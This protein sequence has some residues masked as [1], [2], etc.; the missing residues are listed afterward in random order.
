MLTLTNNTLTEASSFNNWRLVQRIVST[1]MVAPCTSLPLIL[2]VPFPS[3]F[4][5]RLNE[6]KI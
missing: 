2:D 1:L 3:L 6:F 5:P 4:V